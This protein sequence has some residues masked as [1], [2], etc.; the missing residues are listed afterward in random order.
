MQ[1]ANLVDVDEWWKVMDKFGHVY[2]EHTFL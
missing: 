1:Y 2:S